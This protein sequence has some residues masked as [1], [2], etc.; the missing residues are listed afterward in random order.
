[1]CEP[2]L[3]EMR[4]IL[5]I[6]LHP[7]IFDHILFVVEVVANVANEEEEEEGEV[8]GGVVGALAVAKHESL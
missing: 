4:H 6:L 8:V 2:E 7:L 1:M 3:A 5:A